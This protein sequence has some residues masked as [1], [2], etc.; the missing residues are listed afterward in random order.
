[1]R[2]RR[3]RT[4]GLPRRARGCSGGRT[5]PPPCLE[6]ARSSGHS[7]GPRRSSS[8]SWRRTQAAATPPPPVG[9]SRHKGCWVGLADVVEQLMMMVAMAILLSFFYCW[10][11]ELVIFSETKMRMKMIET[12]TQHERNEIKNIS[13]T[14]CGLAGRR[15]K[16]EEK[17]DVTNRRVATMV[18]AIQAQDDG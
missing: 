1:M 12:I 9:K 18:G 11:K 17:K 10:G 14:K 15:E 6:G 13:S 4:Q 2:T 16:K 5:R 7:S 3:K 8:L